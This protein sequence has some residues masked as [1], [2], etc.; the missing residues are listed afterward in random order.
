MDINKLKEI[1]K[2]LYN[3]FTYSYDGIDE[4][5]DCMRKPAQCYLDSCKN[6]WED[7]CDGFHAALYHIY[8]KNGYDPYLLTMILPEKIFE[9]HTI[10]VIK[11]KNQ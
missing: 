3:R 2:K 5:F 7:D 10:C 4:L 11:N 1:Q 9:S 8:Y 6:N